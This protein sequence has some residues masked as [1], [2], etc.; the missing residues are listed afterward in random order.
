MNIHSFL[1]FILII[2]F[3]VQ[4]L[5]SSGKWSVGE[6]VEQSIQNAYIEGIQNS[7]HL[8]YIE[9]QVRFTSL[10]VH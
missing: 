2:L 9:N 1:F 3:K 6:E 7:K 5:R 8:I 4:V 10:K